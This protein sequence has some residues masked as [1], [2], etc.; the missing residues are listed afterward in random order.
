MGLCS[1]VVCKHL[2]MD[3]LVGCYESCTIFVGH[4]VKG[5]LTI[6]VKKEL[7]NWNYHKFGVG[8]QM[9]LIEIHHIT[10]WKI[11]SNVITYS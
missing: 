10:S 7:Q 9:F 3:V 11:H 5:V 6:V 1:I 8:G 2:N 4:I